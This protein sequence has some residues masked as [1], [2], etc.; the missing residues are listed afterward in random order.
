MLEGVTYSER[1]A[2]ELEKHGGIKELTHTGDDAVR[3]T[4]L[5]PSD[6]SGADAQIERRPRG[7]ARF[8]ASD[9][10]FEHSPR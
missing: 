4:T 9:D 5:D 2:A 8:M 6:G 3:R 1:K 10:R 7:I